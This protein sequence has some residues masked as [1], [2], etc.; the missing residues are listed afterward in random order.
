MHRVSIEIDIP[1][2]FQENEKCCGN[3]SR[4]LVFPRLFGV[5]PKFHKCFYNSLKHD[6]CSPFSLANTATRQWETIC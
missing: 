3:M 1:V 6:T 2:E 5:L 4:R